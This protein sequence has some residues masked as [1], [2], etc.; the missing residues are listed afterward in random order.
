MTCTTGSPRG[1]DNCS[2][3]TTHGRH[4]NYPKSFTPQLATMGRELPL[5][6]SPPTVPRTPTPPSRT[7]WQCPSSQLGSSSFKSRRRGSGWSRHLPRRTSPAENGKREG[8][9]QNS[10][11][12]AIG[13]PSPRILRSQ[14]WP[15]NA[16]HLSHRGMFV[17][18]GSYDLTSVL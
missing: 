10:S 2:S 6:A 3:A 4:N 9:L 17:Q 15:S 1:N 5:T 11:R 7:K 18:E 14:R 13:R 8:P 16:Y 12:R